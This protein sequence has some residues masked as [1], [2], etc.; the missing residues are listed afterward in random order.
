MTCQ[1]TNT[2]LIKAFK[3]LISVKHATYEHSYEVENQEDRFQQVQKENHPTKPRVFR[4]FII[5]DHKRY[6]LAD[7]YSLLSG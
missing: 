3:D 6:L 2:A 5:A 1:E 4:W 7:N